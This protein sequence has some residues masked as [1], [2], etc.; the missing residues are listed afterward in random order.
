IYRNFFFLPNRGFTAGAVARTFFAR[1]ARAD[2]TGRFDERA[3]LRGLE[4]KILGT[5]GRDVGGALPRP[6]VEQVYPRFRCRAVFGREIS[7][8]ARYGAYLM[9][10]LDHG[11]VAEAMKLPLAL[12]NA[13]QF[14]ARL[15]HSI[16]P[17]L[18]AYPSAYGHD[19]TGPP[20]RSHRFSEWNTRIRP[21][22]LRQRSYALRRR[23]GP[24][25]DEHGGLLTPD[26]MGRVVDLDFPVMR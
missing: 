20:G 16:D 5:L 11:V 1:Y 8:E 7:L 12:K 21:I 25:A 3:F 14:E 2:L 13:G 23:L 18:A 4:R 26:Y 22:A 10:F 19:F 24:V 9:P 6:V 17:V 15:L